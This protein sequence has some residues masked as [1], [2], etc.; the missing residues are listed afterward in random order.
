MIKTLKATA[1]LLEKIVSFLCVVIIGAMTVTV[2]LGVLFRYVFVNPLGWSEE[3]ARYLM[4]WD[5]SLAISLGVK[6]NEHV[7]L[8]ILIDSIKSRFL[9]LLMDLI[10]TILVF[11]F[12]MLM[13]IYGLPMAMDARYQ[14]SLSLPISMAI[15][16]LAVPVSMAVALVQL[17]LRFLIDMNEKKIDLSEEKAIDI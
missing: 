4:I 6:N 3:L 14:I 7:G 1:F 5:A 9:I 11:A 13:I 8:T 17:I 2:L 16:T 15:P 12:M 10:I